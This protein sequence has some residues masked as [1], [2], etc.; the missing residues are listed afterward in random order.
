MQVSTNDARLAFGAT[1]TKDLSAGAV[2]QPKVRL[3]PGRKQPTYAERDKSRRKLPRAGSLKAQC[4][5]PVDKRLD[6]GESPRQ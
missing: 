6:D 4:L 5:W 1:R 2:R 3:D